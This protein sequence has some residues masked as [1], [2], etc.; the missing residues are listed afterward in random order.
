MLRKT[1]VIA[2]GMIV[3][4]VYVAM[5]I[6]TKELISQMKIIAEDITRKGKTMID[7]LMEKLLEEP[8]VNN[9]EIVFTSRAVEL[10]H[11]ISEKCKGI[12]IV[13]QTREQ[14]EEYAKDLSAEQVYVDM[15]CKI[16]DAPTTLHMKCSVRMLIPI[17]DR[18]LRER[19]L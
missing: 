8:V 3:I 9:D 11:E 14:A 16:V 15:L 5:E 6:A 7:E 10:I 1:A 4:L 2:H 13:E 19:G 18:K 17:I 12:Q